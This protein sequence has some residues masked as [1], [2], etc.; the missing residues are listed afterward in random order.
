M[1]GNQTRRRQANGE[2]PS[3]LPKHHVDHPAA[4]NVRAVASAVVQYV[5]IVATSIC[6]GVGKNWHSVESTIIVN[7]LCD[8]NNRPIVP[9][10][11]SG[12]DS[13]R[14][15]GVGEN[16]SEQGSVD[17]QL[18]TPTKPPAL[19]QMQTRLAK[20]MRR[21]QA[22][23][24]RTP[25][26][27]PPLVVKQSFL[28]SSDISI[29]CVLRRRICTGICLSQ[30]FMIGDPSAYFSAVSTNSL[31]RTSVSKC[32]TTTTGASATSIFGRSPFPE[33]IPASAS[34][35]CIPAILVRSWQRPLIL[36]SRIPST[37]CCLFSGRRSLLT[38]F[39]ESK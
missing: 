15:K 23:T 19:P 34:D 37:A 4:S 13:G 27:T 3:L 17:Y 25:L 28:S 6:Q 30:I 12:V 24:Q 5:G 33:E 18:L 11:P 39:S 1:T 38:L 7:A 10:E 29:R 20:N 31:Q 8:F 16:V 36:H 2:R 22:K 26:P 14:T 9:S 21:P 35:R 32:D